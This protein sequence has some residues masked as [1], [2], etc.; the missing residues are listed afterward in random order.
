MPAAAQN[1][2]HN[3]TGSPTLSTKDR[4]DDR[5]YVVT[6]SRA[7]TVGTQA[8][9]FPAMGFH[10]RGP[11]DPAKIC[12]SSPDEAPKRCDDT[13]YGKGQ[14]GQLRYEIH[15]PA[16]AAQTIWFAA[17]GSDK[18]YE[19]ARDEFDAALAD[20]EA[21]LQQKVADRQALQDYTQ[22]D[23]PGDRQLQE[24]IDWSK[25]NLA[26]AVQY[27][28]DAEIRETN[29]GED[30]P[31]PGGTVEEMRFLGAGWPDYP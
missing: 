4:L 2:T 29:A 31:P 30:Y 18:G 19:A 21:L 12:P 10:T 7:Y 25:Q 11:Q 20:P 13:A 14:G 24:S 26:D 17:A 1:T 5:R 3:A 28:E 6:G 27:V 16:G 9:R 8:G 15:V 23:I 22:L